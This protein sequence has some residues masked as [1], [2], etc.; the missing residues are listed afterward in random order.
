MTR[1]RRYFAVAVLM[2]SMH[3]TS[4]VGARD[5]SWAVAEP[6]IFA[7]ESGG[8]GLKV[9]PVEVERGQMATKA[10][11]VMF[12]L[13]KDGSDKVVWRRPLVNLPSRAYISA[14]QG[15]LVTIDTYANLGYE[16][17]LVVYG[18]KGKMLVNYDLR[19]LLDKDEIS[20]NVKQSATSR[21][22]AEDAKIKFVDGTIFEI[23]L[24]WG[25]VIRVELESG[26]LVEGAKVP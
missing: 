1:L 3:L 25:K 2:G 7:S 24:N 12:G 23:T 11:G 6:P 17:V 13:N 9:L 22:W 21:W 19:D 8:R 15:H 26:E 18:P 10:T 5:D 4:A 20:K 16:H 14:S